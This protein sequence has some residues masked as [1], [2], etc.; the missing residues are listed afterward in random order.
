MLRNRM[1]LERKEQRFPQYYLYIMETSAGWLYWDKTIIHALQC[2]FLLPK[3]GV[4]KV[5][6]LIFFFILEILDFH[7]ALERLKEEIKTWIHSL[8]SKDVSFQE[9]D[10]LWLTAV[11]NMQESMVTLCRNTLGRNLLPWLWR[12]WR[13]TLPSKSVDFLSVFWQYFPILL[14]WM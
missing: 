9:D 2:Y 4:L 7:T 5:I 8:T 14:S 13:I 10:S 1:G 12:S 3:I 6:P 11:R